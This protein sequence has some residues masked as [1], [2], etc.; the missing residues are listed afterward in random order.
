MKV[1]STYGMNR[2]SIESAPMDYSGGVQAEKGTKIIERCHYHR[3]EDILGHFAL[4]LRSGKV[5]S[6]GQPCTKTPKTSYG[7]AFHVRNMAISMQEMPCHSP[8]PSS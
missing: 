1:A 7:G 6:T 2:T 5:D 8:P 4:M 3:M